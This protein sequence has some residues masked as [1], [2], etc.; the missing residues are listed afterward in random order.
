MAAFFSYDKQSAILVQVAL[1]NTHSDE[2]YEEL[3]R[4]IALLK[5]DNRTN[6][7]G[8]LVV[9]V[10]DPAKPRPN[11]TWRKRFADADLDKVTGGT[12]ICLVTPSMLLWGVMKAVNWLSPPN[13]PDQRMAVSNI[14]EAT[15]WAEKFRGQKLPQIRELYEDA[16]RQARQSGTSLAGLG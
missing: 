9:L 5:E 3:M 7:K 11:A 15:T 6:P 8:V 12:S 2:E 16:L 13:P 4:R 1:G 10:F 14:D